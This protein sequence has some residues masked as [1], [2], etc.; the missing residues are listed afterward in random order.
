MRQKKGLIFKNI[1]N[2][3]TIV[4]TKTKEHNDELSRVTNMPKY[5]VYWNENN[6]F[7]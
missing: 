1:F 5:Y 4:S 3:R 6:I 2:K 7:K